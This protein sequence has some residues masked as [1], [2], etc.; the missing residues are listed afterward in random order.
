VALAGDAGAK[1]ILKNNPGRVSTLPIP[2]AEFDLD[3]PADLERL[4]K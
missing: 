2:E 3:T 1:S 4:K